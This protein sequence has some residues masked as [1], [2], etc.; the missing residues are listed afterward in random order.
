MRKNL[1][2]KQIGTDIQNT[3]RKVNESIIFTYDIA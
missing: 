1:T 2:E 3:G